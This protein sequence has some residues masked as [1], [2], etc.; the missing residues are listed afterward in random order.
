MS[1]KYGRPSRQRQ[2]NIPLKGSG[3]IIGERND[4]ITIRTDH[5]ATSAL[6]A[7]EITLPYP[8]FDHEVSAYGIGSG[9][10]GTWQDAVS[11]I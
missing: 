10:D 6:V 1:W 5:F 3:N 7:G 2:I 4:L 8:P 11:V 9:C